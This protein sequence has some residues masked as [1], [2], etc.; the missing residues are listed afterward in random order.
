MTNVAC[1][2]SEK[3]TKNV[4]QRTRA[5]WFS[6]IIITIFMLFYWHYCHSIL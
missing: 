6:I 5:S 4:Q 3:Y 1:M 2:M